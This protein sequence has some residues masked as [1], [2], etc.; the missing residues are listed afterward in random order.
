M[1][2]KNDTKPCKKSALDREID[3]AGDGTV[4]NFARICDVHR[5]T[6]Y[7]WKKRKAEMPLS[8]ALRVVNGSVNRAVELV[9]STF[10]E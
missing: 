8:T 1:K 2:C 6:V 7:K 3:Q 9:K 4:I 5:S 10:S